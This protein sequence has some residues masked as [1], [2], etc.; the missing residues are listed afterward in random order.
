MLKREISLENILCWLR[1]MEGEGEEQSWLDGV[2]KVTGESC[3]GKGLQS[4]PLYNFIF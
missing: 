4:L 1:M 2:K 3:G